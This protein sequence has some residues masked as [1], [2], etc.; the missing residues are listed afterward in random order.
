MPGPWSATWIRTSGPA[1]PGGHRHDAAVRAVARA[2]W[3]RR[4]AARGRGAPGP[5]RRSTRARPRRR[6]APIARD[7]ARRARARPRGSRRSRSTADGRAWSG[8][9]SARARSSM[10][11][12][13][14]PS[15]AAVERA[16]SRPAASV[17]TTPS[18][19]AWS[20]D[21]RTVAGVARSWAMSL[22][23]RRRSISDRSRRSA[24]ALNA[25]ASSVDSRSSPPVARAP[26]SPASSRRAAVA[27]S[28]SGRVSRPAI[29]VDTSTIPSTLTRPA[30]ASVTLNS[31][32]EARVARARRHVGFERRH[33]RA[34]GLDRR[35]VVRPVAGRGPAERGEGRP[36][37]ADDPDLAAERRR[38][39]RRR[40]PGRGRA[41][42]AA[43]GGRPASAMRRRVAAAAGR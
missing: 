36:V 25:S 10:S 26:D 35:L 33:E 2:H 16:A 37:G 34:V 38:Q 42:P 41:R 22:A 31:A 39:A 8:A 6:C 19:I 20:W 3:R 13:T 12:T 15:A 32:Q 27:T 28:C 14:P 40:P 18:I 29:Q 43:T 4:C 23:A 7:A 21:S 5:P 1:R 11:A 9:A 30:T 17:G 24:I